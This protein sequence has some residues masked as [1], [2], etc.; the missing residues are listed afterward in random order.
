MADPVTAI[1]AIAALL[2]V[3]VGIFGEQHILQVGPCADSST[4]VIHLVARQLLDHQHLVPQPEH[5]ERAAIGASE[6]CQVISGTTKAV[7]GFWAVRT[8]SG[9]DYRG[10]KLAC[11]LVTTVICA[12]AGLRLRRDQSISRWCL[13]APPQMCTP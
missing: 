6:G 1:S 11:A 7:S 9:S 2:V 4:L 13:V 3:T 5:A 12:V 10:V 8:C